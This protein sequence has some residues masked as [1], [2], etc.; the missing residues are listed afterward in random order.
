MQQFKEIPPTPRLEDF[1]T[2]IHKSNIVWAY[3]QMI[4]TR[5]I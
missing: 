2:Q 1:P 5:F 4:I 3:V